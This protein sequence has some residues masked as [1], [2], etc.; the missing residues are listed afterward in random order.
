MTSHNNILRHSL[1]LILLILGSACSNHHYYHEIEQ[2]LGTNGRVTSQHHLSA[3][4]P[5]GIGLNFP[6]YIIGLEDS[7][8]ERVSHDGDLIIE[9]PVEAGMD[10]TRISNTMREYYLPFISHIHRYEG[11]RYGKGNCALYSLYQNAHRSIMP[12]C[13]NASDIANHAVD[14]PRS[15]FRNSW[16][17]IEV[18][19][20]EL[21][22]AISSGQYSHM[23]ISMMGLDTAQEESIRNFRSIAWSIRETAGEEFKPL[24]IGITWPSFLDGRWLDPVWELAAYPFKADEADRLG[25]SWLGILMHE[26]IIPLSSQLPTSIISHSFGTRALSM[27]TCVGPAIRNG[28]MPRV[29]AEGQIEKLI[30]FGAAFSLE[31]LRD[32]SIPF[33][34]DIN[35]PNACDKAKSLV[36]TTTD[37]DTAVKLA[38]WADLAGHHGYYEPYCNSAEL[39]YT[40]AC[41]KADIEGNLQIPYQTAPQLFYIDTSELMRYAIPGTQGGAHSD[42]FR[43]EVGRMLWTILQN[44]Q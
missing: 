34:E 31:R 42:I 23:I 21:N 13:D 39:P 4:Y 9:D 18:F 6:G 14:V 32:K 33:Y 3:Y 20:Q 16:Q 22:R 41:G 11:N 8:P 30:G 7:S 37:K 15:A 25:L 24:F 12:F 17:A 2:K 1:T 43:P 26:V 44:Q 29:Y 28:E 19:K 10:I 5:S 36:L 35:Y 38:V 40:I 27:A